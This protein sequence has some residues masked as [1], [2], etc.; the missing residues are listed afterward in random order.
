VER[1]PGVTVDEIKQATEG[2]L[3]VEGVIPEMKI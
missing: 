1:A 2:Q 3:M